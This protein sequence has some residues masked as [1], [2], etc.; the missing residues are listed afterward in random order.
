[1]WDGTRASSIFHPDQTARTVGIATPRSARSRSGRLEVVEELFG[2]HIDT[3]DA[4]ALLGIATRVSAAHG[5]PAKT[6]AAD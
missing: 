4:E 2:R 6:P 1:L 5:W 3:G